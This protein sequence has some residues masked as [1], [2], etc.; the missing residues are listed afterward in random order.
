M[1]C[2]SSGVQGACH[3]CL[4]SLAN[5]GS[6]HDWNPSLFEAPKG[7]HTPE[8]V[9]V[10]FRSTQ[11]LSCDLRFWAEEADHIESAAEIAAA[12]HALEADLH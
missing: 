6:Q 12:I 2:S 9:Q 8:N 5:A 3:K 10:S 7:N 11:A 1:W 4:G